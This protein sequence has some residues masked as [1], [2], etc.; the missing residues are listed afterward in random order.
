MSTRGL[1]DTLWLVQFPICPSVDV[2]VNQ[3][4]NWSWITGIDATSGKERRA[5]YCK[6]E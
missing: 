1:R 4:F 2:D 6:L 3:H 5:L